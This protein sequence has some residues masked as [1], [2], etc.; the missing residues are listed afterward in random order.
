MKETK[1]KVIPTTQLS[2]PQKKYEDTLARLAKF[3]EKSKIPAAR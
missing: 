3:L 1:W 2:S